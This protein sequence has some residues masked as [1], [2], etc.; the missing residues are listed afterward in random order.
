MKAHTA[1]QKRIINLRER[2]KTAKRKGRSTAELQGALALA[3]SQ[4]KREKDARELRT[5]F[6]GTRGYLLKAAARLSRDPEGA[7]DLP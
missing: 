2:I 4:R 3:L 5:A 1:L 7:R 6:A